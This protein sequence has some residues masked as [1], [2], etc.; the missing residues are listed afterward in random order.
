LGLD[1]VED[2]IRHRPWLARVMPAGRPARIAKAF[3]QACLL[4]AVLL[5]CL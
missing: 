3:R 2:F 1:A 4:A 5:F